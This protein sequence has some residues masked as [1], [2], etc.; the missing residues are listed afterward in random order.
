VLGGLYY[1]GYHVERDHAA[2]ARWFGQAAEAGVA[3]AM[4]DL[5]IMHW[6]GK[7]VEKSE[8]QAIQYWRRAA[9]LGDERA[10]A[11]LHQHLSWWGFFR[12]LHYAQLVG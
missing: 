4:T 12:K 3:G 8:R 9:N 10:Q 1:F 7:G 11:K 5:G 2:A 6:A